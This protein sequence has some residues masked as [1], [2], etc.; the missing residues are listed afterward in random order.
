MNQC[1]LKEQERAEIL[2]AAGA[3][4][5]HLGETAAAH[6]RQCESCSETFAQQSA[7]WNHLDS[8]TVPEVS[9]SF[10]RQL[11]AKIDASMAEPWLDRVA[12]QIAWF[13]AQP[14]LAIG[15]A[16]L[17]IVAGFTL[18]HSRSNLQPRNNSASHRVSTSE[19]EQVEKT[20]DDLEMLR[21]FDLNA[22][23]KQATSKS[24]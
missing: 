16:A 18:D 9:S 2:L 13:F 20:L 3:G 6:L 12:R 5:D 15:V 23:E 1:G 21:Q 8:W 11:Y 14:S 10:N 19:A 7:L 4:L 17:V 24:M 22:E